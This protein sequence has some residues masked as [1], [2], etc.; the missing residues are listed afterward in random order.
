M[1][2]LKA[3]VI[4]EKYARRKFEEEHIAPLEIDLE[5]KLLEATAEVADEYRSS[6]DP[7]AKNIAVIMAVVW[8]MV[9]EGDTIISFDKTQSFFTAGR[10]T[11]AASGRGGEIKT[12]ITR[13]KCHQKIEFGGAK[14]PRLWNLTRDKGIA[15]PPTSGWGSTEG[16]LLGGGREGEG[17]EHPQTGP[18]ISAL[19]SWCL[20]ERYSPVLQDVL[21]RSLIVSRGSKKGLEEQA[22][23]SSRM[24][25]EQTSVCSTG[26]AA[27]TSANDSLAVPLLSAVASA[28]CA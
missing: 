13:R 2:A 21:Q 18:S 28:K 9:F 25:E 23:N 12:A 20:E 17:L 3:A 10:L 7:W 14:Y 6:K 8:E 11:A 26:R 5:S 1:I 15:Q 4:I 27:M 22:G 19:V 24:V 16:G